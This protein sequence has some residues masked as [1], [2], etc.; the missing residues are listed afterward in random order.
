MSSQ[1]VKLYK[2]LA[3]SKIVK[4]T[5]NFDLTRIK[6]VLFKLGNP[7]KK[8]KNVINIIGSDGKYSLLTSL[9]Y[10]LEANNYRV[11]FS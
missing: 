2:Q 6:S 5:I 10:F 11:S 1:S 3:K 7:E 8:L 9:K 4:N